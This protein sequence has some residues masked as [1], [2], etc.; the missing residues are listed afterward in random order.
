VIG[1]RNS[2]TARRL[3]ITVALFVFIKI[4][5]AVGRYNFRLEVVRRDDDE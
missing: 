3:P 2:V 5:D 4:T 1:V